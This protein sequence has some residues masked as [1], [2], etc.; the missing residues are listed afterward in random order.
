M[1]RLIEQAEAT[2]TSER[3]EISRAAASQDGRRLC[4]ARQVTPEVLQRALQLYD[5][6]V[7]VAQIEECVSITRT[8]LYR[9]GALKRGL[10]SVCDL[11]PCV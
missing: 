10:L 4:R 1:L 6:G 5:E 7:A 8:T 11:V 2:Y 3:V 9:L